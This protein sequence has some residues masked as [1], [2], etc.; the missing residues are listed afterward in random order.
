MLILVVGDAHI[1]QRESRIPDEFLSLITSGQIEKVVS[2]GN[3]S[4]TYTQRILKSIASSNPLTQVCGEF[5]TPS[6]DIPT[7]QRLVVGNC[8]IGVVSSYI[9]NPIGDLD[10]LTTIARRM[11]VDI[12]LWGGTHLQD[13]S[14]C[15]GYSFINPGSITG[16]ENP[17]LWNTED[18]NVIP[19]FCL[20]EVSDDNRT[21]YMYQLRNGNIKVTKANLPT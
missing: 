18:S 10:A 15:S 19:G 1:P 8:K 13:A 14:F 12:L 16:S 21:I 3:V 20:L 7:E 6:S 5:D 4:G 11:D 17:G 9:I 2:V